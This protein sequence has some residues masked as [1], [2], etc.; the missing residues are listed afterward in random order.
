VSLLACPIGV[1]LQ[2]TTAHNGSSGS[3][4]GVCH[5]NSFRRGFGRQ[6][7]CIDAIDHFDAKLFHC[8]ISG[9]YSSELYC[10]LRR[11]SLR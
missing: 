7:R 6:N 2:N 9:C 4:R 10:W 8:Q 3:M 1:E 5:R 11:Q